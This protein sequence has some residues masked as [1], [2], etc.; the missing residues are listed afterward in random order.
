MRPPTNYVLCPWCEDLIPLIGDEDHDIITT[1][2]DDGTYEFDIV[3]L[4]EM[5]ES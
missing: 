3:C 2:H 5:E 4:V 1:P